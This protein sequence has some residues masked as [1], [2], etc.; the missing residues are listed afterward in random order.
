MLRDLGMGW[1][2]FWMSSILF[3]RIW[4]FS[5][6]MPK[7]WN[8]IKHMGS[9]F[10]VCFLSLWDPMFWLCFCMLCVCLCVC[11]CACCET[12]RTCTVVCMSFLCYVFFGVWRCFFEGWANNKFEYKSNWV[13]ATRGWNFTFIPL[14]ILLIQTHHKMLPKPRPWYIAWICDGCDPNPSKFITKW[15]LGKTFELW[16][17]WSK[18]ITKPCNFR[19][20]YAKKWQWK[21]HR[22]LESCM[23]LCWV[24]I[25]FITNRGLLNKKYEYDFA[26]ESHGS[27]LYPRIFETKPNLIDWWQVWAHSWVKSMWLK[28]QPAQIWINFI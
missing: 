6:T 21:S 9:A 3:W 2:Q 10:V 19:R 11:L 27:R 23:V 14:F 12:L 16:W 28:V 7:K 13:N 22:G 1:G 20:L 4:H 17:T 25:K 5:K 15:D 26:W 18:L 24:W 8:K